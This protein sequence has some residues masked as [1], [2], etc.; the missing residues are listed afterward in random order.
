MTDETTANERPEGVSPINGQEPPPEYRFK[1]GN[2]A[3]Q[4]RRNGFHLTPILKRLAREVNPK[5]KQG[6]TNAELLAEATLLHAMKGNSTAM[7]EAWER[8]DG[9]IK[10]ESENK[11][12]LTVT[13]TNDWRNNTA[14]ANADT[15]KHEPPG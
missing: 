1:P 3:A 13:Y 7:K 15:E 2:K 10:E 12:H 4:G 5:D 14:D 11:T 9:K 8:L 6:R